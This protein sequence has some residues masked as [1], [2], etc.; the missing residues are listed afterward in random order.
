M[1]DLKIKIDNCIKK[2]LD[3][4]FEGEDSADI[5]N[6][7]KYYIRAHELTGIKFTYSDN[8]IN[9]DNAVNLVMKKEM[10]N[11]WQIRDA[12]VRR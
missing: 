7:V 1:Q 8:H 6:E 11:K 5:L 2:K 4:L 12:Y 10:K 9:F 3:I